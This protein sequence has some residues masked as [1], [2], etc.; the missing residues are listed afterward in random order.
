MSEL[1]QKLV[2]LTGSHENVYSKKWCKNPLKK[3]FNNAILFAEVNGK[4][5]VVCF[6]DTTSSIVND[7]SF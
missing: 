3:K 7:A 5:D 4:T 1:D 6:V 2:E